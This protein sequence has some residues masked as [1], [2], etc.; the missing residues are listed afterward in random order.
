MFTSQYNDSVI[1]W[2]FD[3]CVLNPFDP[4]GGHC[5]WGPIKP[6]K[7]N[8]SFEN[9]GKRLSNTWITYP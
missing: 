8:D 1:N 5:Y 7:S 2:I 6:C 4:G 9:R 3:F